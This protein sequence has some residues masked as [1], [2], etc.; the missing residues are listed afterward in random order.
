MVFKMDIKDGQRLVH[1]IEFRCRPADEKRPTSVEQ[2]A[3]QAI[4]IE[5]MMEWLTGYRCHVSLVNP[6]GEHDGPTFLGEGTVTTSVSEEKK[7]DT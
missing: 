3:N 5:Q 2:Q 7:A 4:F 1:S 6:D